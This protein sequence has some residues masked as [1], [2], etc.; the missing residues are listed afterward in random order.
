[1]FEH[2]TRGAGFER[3]P[4]VG[5]LRVHGEKDHPHLLVVLLQP[6]ER[7]NAVEMRHGDVGHDHVRPKLL[8]RFDQGAAILDHAHQFKLGAEQALQ[9]FG[10]H[11]MVIGQQHARTQAAA[12]D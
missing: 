6:H 2:V 3:A 12:H 7:V 8:R 11:A 4:R 5:H 1:M 9:A 10:H